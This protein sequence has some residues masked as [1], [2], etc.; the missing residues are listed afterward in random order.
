MARDR[1]SIE[2]LLQN[3]DPM[4]GMER[5]EMVVTDIQHPFAMVA[6]VTGK[7]NPAQPKLW[8]KPNIALR[9]EVGSEEQGQRPISRAYTVRHF[10]IETNLI[11]IDFII[12]EGDA[13]AMHWLDKAKRGTSAFMTGPRQ[14]FVPNYHLGG[15]I[16][17]FADDTAIPALYA[18]LSQWP[19]T[20][21][22]AVYID[23][24]QADYAAELPA[25]DGVAYHLH[26]RNRGEVAGKSNYLPAMARSLPHSQNWQIWVACEREEARTIRQHFIEQ[27]NID[28]NH[29][30]AIG[31]WKY[32]MDSS[33]LD[34]ARLRYYAKLH[35]A[36]QT[37]Q[38]S[39][40]LDMPL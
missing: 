1:Y 5:L 13:P 17:F 19:K 24:A 31:Y 22:A 23:C 20:V 21:E 35:T 4:A 28:K 9:M 36:G 38:P 3:N 27:H 25:I 33:Q 7:I 18:I 30:K 16:A 8:A 32:G 12:H 26:V 15:K 6:R 29:I 11:E 14:H 2:K 34:H 37:L 10:N 39:E 40:E